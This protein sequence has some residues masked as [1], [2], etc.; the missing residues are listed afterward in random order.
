MRSGDTQRALAGTALPNP[1]IIIPQDEKGRTV[2]NQTATFTIIAGGGSLSSSTGTV[3]GDG[4]ITAP[5]WTLGNT[6]TAQEMRV[7]IG[8]KT[9]I[10]TASIQTSYTLAVRFF[11]APVKTE[12]GALFTRAAA[13]IRA[14][15]VG[16]LPLV[17]V[18]GADVTPCTGP[19]SN[20][21]PLTGTIDGLVIYASVDSIDGPRKVLGQAG[22]CFIREEN[23]VLDYRTVIGIMKFDSA[24]IAALFGN[25]NLQN[26]ITH[27]ML[28]T[29]GVGTF[30]DDKNL[31]INSGQPGAA[32]T[33]ARGIAG[34]REVGG[35][36][37]CTSSVPVEDCEGIPAALNC[38]EGQREGHW[39]ETTFGTELMTSYLSNTNFLSVMTIRSLG[40]LNYE[41][42][43][44]A[45][46][47]YTVPTPA[48][49]FGGASSS[50]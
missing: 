42:N 43:P 47:P 14:I 24:D 28:H 38:G 18:E 5:T 39:K 6:D 41:V 35:T 48:F 21:A 15:V 37:I 30:W 29:L 16:G 17:N 32:Y 3:N 40:D 27:E 23:G 20:V 10:V 33:G 1:I 19:G 34:C 26:V 50:A 25:E 11:G 2:G 4:T 31:L 8:A 22:P 45:A 12:H 13:R 49:S 9:L 36:A 46:D 7:Q 44:A